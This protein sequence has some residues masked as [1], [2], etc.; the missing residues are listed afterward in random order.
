MFPERRDFRPPAAYDLFWTFLAGGFLGERIEVVY[1]WSAT[2]EVMS[3]SSLLYGPFSLV[4]GLGAALV[5][6]CLWPFRHRG[7]WVLLVAGGVLGGGFEYVASAVGE[8]M[9]HKIFWDY[10]HMPF[11]LGGRTNLIFALLWGLGAALWVLRGFPL[12][13]RLTERLPPRGGQAALRV[14]SLVLAADLLLSAAAL[15]R[16]EEREAAALDTPAQNEL[17]RQVM[18]LPPKYRAAIYLYYYEGYAVAE[19]AVLMGAKASTVQTWLMRARG[20]L[21]IKLKE[22]EACD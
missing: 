15:L 13:A 10:S 9:Y 3:R 20:Q 18:A 7:P 12:L 19:V 4:W 17:F 1:I 22:A 5:T 16:M 2:G 6:W 8:A 21:K 11:H 14:L